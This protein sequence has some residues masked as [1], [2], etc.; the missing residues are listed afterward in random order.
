MSSP[1]RTGFWEK[2]DEYGGKNFDFADELQKVMLD[3]EHDIDLNVFLHGWCSIFAFAL[4][5][6]YGY[7][8][9]CIIDEE[10]CGYTDGEISSFDFPIIHAFCVKDEED[11]V[12]CRG[13]VDDED[14]F[15]GEF[16]DFF[17]VP[18]YFRYSDDDIK[19]LREEIWAI[20]PNEADLYYTC[21]CDYIKANPSVFTN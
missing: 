17:T 20:I 12:D 13:I 5:D 3:V 21:C 1:Y 16:E 7:P 9:S 11:L 2:Y 15:L 4:H 14:D 18:C 6:I 19:N 10:E 8:I